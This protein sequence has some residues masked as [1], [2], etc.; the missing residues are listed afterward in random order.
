MVC[1]RS[2]SRKKGGMEGG[3]GAKAEMAGTGVRELTDR[4][5]TDGVR[6][7]LADGSAASNS[8]C[9]SGNPTPPPASLQIKSGLGRT[10]ACLLLSQGLGG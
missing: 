10:A 2:L 3:G 8:P 6:L 9:T 7:A 5:A 1:S 4:D